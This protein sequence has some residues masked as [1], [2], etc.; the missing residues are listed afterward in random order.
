MIITL[1]VPAHLKVEWSSGYYFRCIQRLNIWLMV[2]KWHEKWCLK[3][4]HFI[5]YNGV[6]MLKKN[7]VSSCLHFPKHPPLVCVWAKRDSEFC[8]E[9]LHVKPPGGTGEK[10]TEETMFCHV[11]DC[12]NL[13][14]LQNY[15]YLCAQCGAGHKFP[16]KPSYVLSWITFK[17]TVRER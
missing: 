5:K 3:R 2:Q 4:W 12:C 13:L 1:R 17:G 11:F 9:K 8:E 14:M 7:V 16:L 15:I 6:L 10:V